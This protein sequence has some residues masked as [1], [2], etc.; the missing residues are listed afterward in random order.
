MNLLNTNSTNRQ[1]SEVC[2]TEREESCVFYHPQRYSRDL[3]PFANV[4]AHLTTDYEDYFCPFLSSILSFL[5][6]ELVDKAYMYTKYPDQQ[7]NNAFR[8]IDTEMIDRSKAHGC[9]K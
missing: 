5:F 3:L 1:S 2:Y 6:S 8:N 7:I 9:S 4:V